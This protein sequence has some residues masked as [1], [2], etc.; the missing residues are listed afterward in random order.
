MQRL[1]SNGVFDYFDSRLSLS[2]A[3]LVM[4]SSAPAKSAGDAR[5][6]S[7]DPFIQSTLP[8]QKKPLERN[9]KKSGVSFK[10]ATSA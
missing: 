5:Y 6:V 7:K 3:K 8:I 2:F 4:M 9:G 1:G 10:V